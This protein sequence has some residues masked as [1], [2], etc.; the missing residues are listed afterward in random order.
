[1]ASFGLGALSRSLGSG[2]LSFPVTHFSQDMA[3]DLDGQARHTDFLLSQQISALFA[4]GGTG[5]FFSL[6]DTELQA[7]TKVT[8]D[9]AAGK[10]PV[11]ASAGYTTEV[12]VAQARMAE[13]LGAAGVLLFPPYLMQ[14][15]Q[16]GLLERAVSVCRSTELGVVYYNR[17]N[18]ILDADTLARLAEKCPN[19]IALKDGTGSLE[20]NL[21]IAGVLADRLVY[22]GGVPTAE[23]YASAYKDIGFNTYSSAL[24]NFA[25]RF[26]LDFY[27]AVQSGD[28]AFITTG[29][30][31]LAPYLQMR[32]TLSG[33][34]VAIVKAGMVATDR[35]AGPV[36]PPLMDYDATSISHLRA[37]LA[38]LPGSVVHHG[39][40]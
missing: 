31:F 24:Y 17:G 8:L 20:R 6:N 37:L 39:E 26:A 36:R 27:H 9:G 11:L 22:I 3:L 13:R 28:T 30:T 38:E 14:A 21:R 32:D 18:G 10:V 33:G 2:L 34:A 29:M 5:E 15:P 35:S 40:H 1:M 25:P 12:A 7:V 19:F 23:L 4:A 16:E